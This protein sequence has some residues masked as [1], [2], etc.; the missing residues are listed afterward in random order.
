MRNG[1]LPIHP[2]GSLIV[3]L[4][5]FDVHQIKYCECRYDTVKN[6]NPL[7]VNCYGKPVNNAPI[8]N[9]KPSVNGMSRNQLTT[10]IVLN[11]VSWMEFRPILPAPPHDRIAPGCLLNWRRWLY[12]LWWLR[13]R[14]YSL[15]TFQL[16]KAIIDKSANE[17]EASDL[18]IGN[19]SRGTPQG[20][21]H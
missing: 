14:G 20:A 11:E 1:H 4:P 12:L 15:I 5:P 8:R 10:T 21:K 19:I 18:F 16:G 2:T 13:W 9:E 17:I 6:P 7:K 3:C